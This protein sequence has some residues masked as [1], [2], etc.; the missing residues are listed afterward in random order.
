MNAA[1]FKV[2]CI[3]STWNFVPSALRLVLVGWASLW[4]VSNAM[5]KKAMVLLTFG[6]C[7]QGGFSLENLETHTENEGEI[8]KWL[9]EQCD[10][11]CHVFSDT[12]FNDFPQVKELLENI[13]K[14]RVGQQT[15]RMMILD[16]HRGRGV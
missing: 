3:L 1:A 15:W 10:N 13:V 14:G 6:E 7:L 9:L 12:P 4:P 16:I 5:W 2:H 8:L 11:R